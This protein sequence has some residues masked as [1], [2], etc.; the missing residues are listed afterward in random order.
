MKER[1]E[2]ILIMMEPGAQVSDEQL[3]KL[4]ADVELREGCEDV[5]I[6]GHLLAREQSTLDVEEE[7]KNFKTHC[8]KENRR[9]SFTTSS[10]VPF[11]KTSIVKWVAVAAVLVGALVLLWPTQQEKYNNLFF[12]HDEH[13]QRI[14]VNKGNGEEIELGLAVSQ[15]QID[16][17]MVMSIEETGKDVTVNVPYGKSLELV[18]PDSS[19]VFMHPGSQ[20]SYSSL[21]GKN[22]RDV[23]L[24]GEAY[25]V[26]SKDCH[27]PFTVSTE[28]TLTTVFGT[29]FDV[30]A[31]RDRPERISL[32]SGSVSVKLNDKDLEW[33]IE[34]GQQLNL[35]RYGYAVVE[36]AD[37]EPFVSWRDGFFYFDGAE[38]YDIL[39]ELGR[40]YN[41][42]IECHEPELL[43]YHMRFIIPRNK[44][45]NY[46]VE[47]INRMQKVHASLQGT[48]IVVSK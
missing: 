13:P 38:L 18:L 45:I 14:S 2:D 7:L 41:V 44:D 12:T 28:K 33:Q 27:R 8:P 3:H 22:K 15:N 30:T 25:F 32:V 47:M 31:W 40:C 1:S 20:L 46:A 26:V 23:K 21:F 43:K 39:K 29:E 11:R 34:P 36:E 19:H 17:K 42:S 24:R 35:S 37:M 48:T 6:A 9:L 4:D 10:F 16:Q 5:F